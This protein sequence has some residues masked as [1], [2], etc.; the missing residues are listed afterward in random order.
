M[1]I[2]V[3]HLPSPPRPQQTLMQF[4]WNLDPVGQILFLPSIICVLIALQWAGTVYAWSSA[5]IIVLMVVFAVLLVAFVI[6]ELWM[7]SKATIPP[8]VA[9]QRTVAAASCF[10]FFNY[11][12]FFIFVYFIPIYFQA[13]KG[14]NAE[15]SGI[16]TI[17]LIVAN[18]VASLTSGIL[19]T[20]FGHYVPFFYGCSVLTSIGA[21]LITTWQVD[22]SSSKWIGYQIISGFGTGLAL[23]L[24]Q[25]AVQP[26]LAP[27]DIP[28]GISMTIFLQFFGGA[29]FVS[30][31][32]NILN[33][34]LVQ[35][36]RDIGIP[37][38][39]ASK[40]IDSGATELRQAVPAEYLPQVLEAY[41]QAL[42]LVFRAGL[43]MA[44]L[45]VLAALP[46]EWRSMKPPAAAKKRDSEDG[47][48]SGDEKG[49]GVGH[50]GEK[51]AEHVPVPVLAA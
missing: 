11:A 42:R 41:N 24:P 18:N 51:T 50:G 1:L 37:D 25:V 7:G 47:G 22:S 29:L 46:L 36:V 14:T 23:A 33:S 21:G 9:S 48:S 16:N 12:Q 45:S 19:T 13:I 40:I 28:I 39:D 20:M 27:Q 17:P 2:A 15:R 31:G 43:A 38:F 26:G 32:N 30:V 8:K 34:K 4:I 49:E 5:R 10:A 44:C 6:N 3:L 35:Y